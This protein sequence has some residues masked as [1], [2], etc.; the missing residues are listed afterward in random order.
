MLRVISDETNSTVDPSEDPF[1]GEIRQLQLN[2]YESNS[3]MDH[4]FQ[5]H[6]K[7]PSFARININKYRDIVKIITG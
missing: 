1:D 3:A 5:D 7:R 6:S 2:A 4:V